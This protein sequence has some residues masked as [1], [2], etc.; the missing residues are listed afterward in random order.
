[1]AGKHAT[2]K[3]EVLIATKILQSED[4]EYVSFDITDGI[5]VWRNAT[6]SNQTLKLSVYVD[7]PWRLSPKSKLPPVIVFD[8]PTYGKS[9][10]APQRP[11]LV[12]ET[13][14]DEE[15][16]VQ[17]NLLRHRRKRQAV[18]GA[19]NSEFCFNNPTESNCCIRNLTVDV[20]KD[21]GL[22]NIIF[23][24]SFQ[25]N[26]CSGSCISPV[27]S[28]ANLA[29]KYLQNIRLNNPT[30]A[31]EPCCV[32]HTYRPLSILMRDGE[33]YKIRDIPNMIVTSCICR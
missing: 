23:P 11:Q 9:E 12:V 17:K 6:A 30:A 8:V 29:T 20:H 15:L 10:G 5:K 26:Y 18:S 33:H 22:S 1:M 14:R 21:L 19:A 3:L 16:L 7:T 2:D 24:T 28:S 25:P 27:W 13:V 4:D 31:P 32:P